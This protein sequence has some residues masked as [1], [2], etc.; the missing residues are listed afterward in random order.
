VNLRLVKDPLTSSAPVPALEVLVVD[1]E[2]ATREVLSEFCRAVGLTVTAAGDGRSAITA[3]QREP[4]RFRV[5]FTDI[6][7]SGADGFEVLRAVR[8]ANPS[9]YVVMVTGYATLDSA[10][11]AVREGAYDY[12]PKPFALGQIEVVVARLRDRIALEDENRTLSRQVDG[13]REGAGPRHADATWRL[14]AIEERLG[15]I[16]DLLRAR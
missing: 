13:M 6:F 14:D 7:M 8:Q 12:L 3:I 16:E 10:L 5:I 15:R 2:A 9:A 4:A 11:R 1:D